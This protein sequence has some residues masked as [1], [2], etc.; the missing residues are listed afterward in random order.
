VHLVTEENA[1]KA[2]EETETTA[3]EA[4]AAQTTSGGT[5]LGV[6]TGVGAGE[7]ATDETVAPAAVG[8]RRRN[9]LIG[10]AVLGVVAG[11]AGSWVYNSGYKTRAANNSAV[12]RSAAD[13]S[14]YVNAGDFTMLTVPI[15]ND[16]PDAITVIGLSLPDVPRIRWDGRQ[17]VIQPGM[18]AYLRVKTPNDCWAT[19]HPI[20]DAKPV[21]VW[22]RVLTVNGKVH[23]PLKAAVSGVIQYAADHC[24]PTPSA[25]ST[26]G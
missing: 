9:G 19:P 15:R 3:H 16:S 13:P 6:G 21:N 11:V 12:I 20:A 7:A 17:T 26:Q 2:A 18:T 22:L 10:L 14:T 23:A 24:T 5:G 8:R 1:D 25:S 4:A